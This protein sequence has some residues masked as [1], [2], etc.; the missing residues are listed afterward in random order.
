MSAQSYGQLIAL[1]TLAAAALISLLQGWFVTGIIL[2][3]VLVAM[4]F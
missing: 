1:G 4:V 2:I 3:V